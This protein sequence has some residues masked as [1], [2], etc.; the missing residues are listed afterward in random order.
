ML[1][2]RCK[3]LVQTFVV[4][5]GIHDRVPQQFGLVKQVPD[6]MELGRIALERR[7]QCDELGIQGECLLSKAN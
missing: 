5:I 1:T 3:R 6:H 7:K 4:P 2:T